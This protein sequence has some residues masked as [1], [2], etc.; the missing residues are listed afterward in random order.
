MNVYYMEINGRE[1]GYGVTSAEKFRDLTKDIGKSL[2]DSAIYDAIEA[3]DIQRAKA[4]QNAKNSFL[5]HMDS[6]CDGNYF[7]FGARDLLKTTLGLD[8]KISYVVVKEDMDWKLPLA[9]FLSPI[10]KQIKVPEP[11]K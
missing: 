3:E 8:M 5:K 11:T 4:C 10:A 1:L 9:L 7:S 2:F 6:L